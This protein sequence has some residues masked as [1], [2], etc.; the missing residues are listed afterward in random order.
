MMEFLCELTEADIERHE[1]A[2]KLAHADMHDRLRRSADERTGDASA[3]HPLVEEG[4]P[5]GS[6]IQ[7][8][9]PLVRKSNI[10]EKYV[11]RHK[12]PAMRSPE[13]VSG[14]SSFHRDSW[15]SSLP[16]VRSSILA[17]SRIADYISEES[18]QRTPE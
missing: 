1:E 2:A 10:E 7:N 9:R 15:I 3:L 8:H 18:Y 12:K 6:G 5:S 4:V 13:V 17:Y 14:S 16:G 11:A